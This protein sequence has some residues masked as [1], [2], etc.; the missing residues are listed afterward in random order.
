MRKK[1][2]KM[3]KRAKPILLF[4]LVFA[5]VALLGSS[6]AW[7]VKPQCQEV[8]IFGD[9]KFVWAEDCP[10]GSGQVFFFDTGYGTCPGPTT[11]PTPTTPGCEA[12]WRP[13][14]PTQLTMCTCEGTDCVADTPGSP[15]SGLYQ[16]LFR[17]KND[18]C[19]D[20]GEQPC[21]VVVECLL[22]N[23]TGPPLGV[24]VFLNPSRGCI[25][26]RCFR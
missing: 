12:C 3:L 5:A 26:S 17:E 6:P 15:G 18:V 8:Q 13:G 23:D 10:A 24:P 16:S 14:L 22:V 21:D 1:E 4:T 25:G 7:A 19:G 20:D 11:C 2:D 9:V